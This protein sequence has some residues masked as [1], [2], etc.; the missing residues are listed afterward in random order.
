MRP[1]LIGLALLATAASA[2]EPPASTFRSSDR[3]V[4]D[5]TVSPAQMEA[6][7]AQGAMVIDV[8]LAE[9]FASNPVL[10]PGAER[11]DPEQI[12]QWAEAMPGGRP[13]VLYCVKG[14]WVSQKA[15]SILRRRNLD[16][17]SLSGG[18][19]AWTAARQSPIPPG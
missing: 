1:H 18:L 14:A 13:I 4:Y 12:A 2:G 10:I 16:V 7:A 3:P 15:A 17:Y 9:D 19:V 5:R 6:L 8:R 11:R